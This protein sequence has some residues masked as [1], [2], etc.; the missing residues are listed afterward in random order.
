MFMCFIFRL[1]GLVFIVTASCT[2]PYIF[3]P[4][5]TAALQFYQAWVSHHNP[6]VKNWTRSDDKCNVS[7]HCVIATEKLEVARI[8][9]KFWEI[10]KY[11]HAYRDSF[12]IARNR[13]E[14][15][16]VMSYTY[17]NYSAHE[18]I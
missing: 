1:S 16:V 6:E 2:A 18:W 14:R 8:S 4:P 11:H 13:Q 15:V 17:K 3:I 9:L 7:S 10:P 5:N 12:G